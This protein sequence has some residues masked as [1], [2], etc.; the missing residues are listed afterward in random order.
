MSI[1]SL[2]Q[3]VT[4]AQGGDRHALEAVVHAVSKDVYNLALR[5]LWCP[6]DAADACQEILL[7]IVTRLSTFEGRSAFRT[8]IYRVALNHLLNQKASRMEAKHLSFE[9]FGADLAVGL[10]DIQAPTDDPEHLL[11][12]DEVRIG[13]TH[14]MLICLDREHRAAFVLGDILDLS[15]QEACD[16]LG[17]ADAAFRKR[18][19][20]ARQ[21]ILDFMTA[22][23]GLVNESAAC[24]CERRV[25]HACMTGIADPQNLLFVS[26]G[27]GVSDVR[28]HVDNL[29]GLQR[30]IAVY[31]GNPSAE[32]PAESL[33]LVAQLLNANAITC[34]H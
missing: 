21:R 28:A 29:T 5:M 11:L 3:L 34:L 13:C 23:C 33:K 18:L 1:Q 7:K 16:I 9:Q 20:R 12:V 8:W 27:Y 2:E 10:A 4:K 31:R 15:S 17:I 25:G 19:S 14:A 30:V 22:H 26:A 32:E 24:R 6:H